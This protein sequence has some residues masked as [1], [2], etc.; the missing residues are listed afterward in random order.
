MKAAFGDLKIPLTTDDPAGGIVGTQ[1]ALAQIEF[2]GFRM[3]RILDCG[4]NITMGH[5]AD[6]YRVTIVFLA[7]MD[8]LDA[9]HTKLQLGFVAGAT[10]PTGAR[11]DAVQCG[12]T[13]VIEAKLVALANAR[14]K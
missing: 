8:S 4:E 3:S 5:R 6:T 1:R 13:G 10:P 9:S 7:L 12:S 14:L 2:A 11:S